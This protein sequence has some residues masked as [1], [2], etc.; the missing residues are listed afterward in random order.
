MDK[1][2]LIAM[3]GG[4]DSSVAA[5]LMKEQGYDCAGAT[6]RLYDKFSE[7]DCRNLS[8]INDAESVCRKLG[9]DFHVFDFR[10][11]FRKGVIDSFVSSYENGATPNPCAVCNRVMKF[12]AFSDAAEKIGIASIATGHYARIEKSNGRY[13]LKKAADE[14]KDQTYFLYSLNQ[15][16]LS[17]A[18]F[19][20][21]SLAKTE[22]RQIAADK[23]FASAHKSDSQDICF[24]ADGEY[25]ALIKSYTGK[26]YPEGN[27]IDTEGRIIGT[28]RG[29]IN[30]TIGQRKGLG[31]A[32]GERL[33]VKN[34][35]AV[36]NEV[37][38]SNDD[39]LYSDALRANRL[40]WI[41]FE[42]MSESFR[43]YAK[44]RYAAKEEPCTVC[45]SGEDEISVKFDTPQRAAAR[46]QAIVFYDGD[47]VIGG[48]TII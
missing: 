36:S 11:E 17:R 14:R 2:V 42:K 23:G 21:G 41:A 29:I 13:F 3:S 19:P 25:A 12:G 26:T 47:I 7:H 38:L 6:M 35:N 24:V 22:I 20:L 39:K 40:N 16:Q 18:H 43:A 33:Y 46:G 10:E 37:M 34:K 32:F 5:Y 9:M 1:K 15:S 8:D 48:G 44:I 28:H 45:I 30:Y 27:F 31:T 4:V